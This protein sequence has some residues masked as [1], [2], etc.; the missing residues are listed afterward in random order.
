MQANLK[1]SPCYK[2]GNQAEK[3]GQQFDQFLKLYVTRK[4]YDIPELDEKFEE[5]YDLSW[6]DCAL[7]LREVSLQL[8][9]LENKKEILR[10]RLIQM[11]QEKDSKGFGVFVTKVQRK[12]T[13]DYSSIP[14]LKGVDLEKYRKCSSE[15]W[16]ISIE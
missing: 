7:Q 15:Y 12:G 10:N 8:E 11:S 3:E 5:K 16:K 1:E 14:E 13:I 2:P 6:K 9:S 4:L